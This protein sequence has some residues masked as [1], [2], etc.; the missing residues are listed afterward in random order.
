MSLPQVSRYW[1]CLT[2]PF[3]PVIASNNLCRHFVLKREGVLPG[4]V[5][6]L[7]P[8]ML[9]CPGVDELGG[10]ANLVFVL[11]DAALNLSRRITG[12]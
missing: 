10:N 3:S 12:I 7:R 9:P 5:I 8:H 4:L 11:P 1:P 6:A 2:W